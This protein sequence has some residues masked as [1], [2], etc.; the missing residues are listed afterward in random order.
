MILLVLTV[1]GL[2]LG[3][4]VNALVWRLHEQLTQKSNK[5]NPALSILRGHSMCPH[6]HHRLSAKDLVPLL[7][8]L[9]LGGKCRYCHEPISWQYPLVEVVLPIAMIVSYVYWPLSF[10]AAGLFEFGVWLV[11]LVGLLA[12]AVYDVR[13]MIL[14][15]RIVKPLIGLS[16]LQVLVVVDFY[17]GGLSTLLGALWG[18]LIAAGLFYVLFQASKGKWIGGGD[19]KL[20]IAIGL[21]LGGPLMSLLM[22]FVA[23][24]IGAAVAL[25]MLLTGRTRLSSRLAFGPFLIVATVVVR[26]FGAG[27]I[28]WYKRQY[29][30]F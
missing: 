2:C 11:V 13:W 16:L 8:W 21:L 19:V 20:G 12:L 9:S 22:I 18:V 17:H 10:H 3:S 6:C 29:V 24:V 5:K 23:S 7:S 14:P 4:F 28:A 27:L 15:S 25:P 30:G 26:L 1:L